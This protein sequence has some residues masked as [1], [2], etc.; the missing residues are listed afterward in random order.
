MVRMDP[1]KNRLSEVVAELTKDG[2]NEVFLHIDEF[3][4]DMKLAATIIRGCIRSFL[5]PNLKVYPALS[6][7][8]TLTESFTEL[9]GTGW[10]AS[11][12]LLQ[13]FNPDDKNLKQPSSNA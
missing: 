6:G 5:S 13:P 9:K 12:I 8:Q 2:L 11:P 3:H 7:L 10:W 4:V 1:E